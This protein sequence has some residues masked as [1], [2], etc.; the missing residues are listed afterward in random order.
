MLWSCFTWCR[1][2]ELKRATCPD[3]CLIQTSD[4][5][6]LKGI[7]LY[8]SHTLLS[9]VGANSDSNAQS[10]E[11]TSMLVYSWA[12]GLQ[13]ADDIVC[14]LSHVVALHGLCL[15]SCLFGRMT[16]TAQFASPMPAQMD[17]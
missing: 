9:H 2:N 12:C 15:Q 7:L 3:Q 4:T 16:T 13:H 5:S 8:K 11:F 1:P 10:F 17:S 14:C 6:L